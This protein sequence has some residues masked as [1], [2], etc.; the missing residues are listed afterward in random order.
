MEENVPD[1]Q[2][3]RRNSDSVVYT[4]AKGN[5]VPAVFPQ[6]KETTLKFYQVKV[7]RLEEKLWKLMEKLEQTNKLSM[8]TYQTDS[9]IA[10]FVPQT[11]E[12]YEHEEYM[13]REFDGEWNT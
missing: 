4:T 10:G 8:E 13:A 2:R 6:T 1:R 9:E 12:P 3:S 11:G 7:K 5:Y